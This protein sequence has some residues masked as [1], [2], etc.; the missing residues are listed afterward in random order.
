LDDFI[1]PCYSVQAYLRTYAHV[2]QPIEGP[3]NWSISD[4]LRPVPPHYV[5]MPGRPK[6]ERRSEEGE[7]PKG[8]KLSRVGIKM[9]C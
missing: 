9:R 6:T 8:K 4:M 1:A 7:Q 3:G 2:L 5:K